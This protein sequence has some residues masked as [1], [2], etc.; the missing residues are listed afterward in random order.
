MIFVPVPSVAT[1]GAAVDKTE[2]NHPLYLWENH[3]REQ[4]LPTLIVTHF[5]ELL[6]AA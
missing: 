4:F 6:L 3:G 1:K 5:L 2:R